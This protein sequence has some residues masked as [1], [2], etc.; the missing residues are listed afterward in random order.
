[1]LKDKELK[2]IV[3]NSIKKNEEALKLLRVDIAYGLQQKEIARNKLKVTSSEISHLQQTLKFL[4][5]VSGKDNKGKEKEIRAGS[6][7]QYLL[8]RKEILEQTMTGAGKLA[9]VFVGTQEYIKFLR[10]LLVMANND[11]LYRDVDDYVQKIQETIN[12]EGSGEKGTGKEREGKKSK[13]KEK[14]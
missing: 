9:S 6:R 14:T 10:E 13:G 5:A 11:I 12:K 3:Q 4:G 1:M 7:L 2:K 8:A